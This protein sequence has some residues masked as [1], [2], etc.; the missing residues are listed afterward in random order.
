M[1]F[2]KKWGIVEIRRVLPVDGQTPS[3]IVTRSNRT[4]WS[5]GRLLLFYLDKQADNTN[6]QN[7]DLD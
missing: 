4:L 6:D 7:A 5:E 2:S 3:G 1:T